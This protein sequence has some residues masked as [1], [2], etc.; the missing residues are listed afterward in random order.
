MYAS[1]MV[2]YIAYVGDAG[3][4][5]NGISTHLNFAKPIGLNLERGLK[6]A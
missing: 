1:V 2:L 3:I 5:T 4:P 6:C